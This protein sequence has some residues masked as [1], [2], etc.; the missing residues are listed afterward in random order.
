M[1]KNSVKATQSL[2]IP[3]LI[4]STGKFLQF[5][6]PKLAALFAARLFTT[7]LKYKIPK[8]ELEMDM[9]SRQQSVDIKSIDKE[10]VVYHFG[11][12]GKKVLLVHGWSG[13]GTQLVK[14]ADEFVKAGYST[15][16]FDAPAHGKSPGKTT[17]MPEFIATILQLEKEFGPFEAAVGH[18][19]GG[20]SLLNSVKRGLKLER[21]V[22]IGSG[23]IIQDIIDEFIE[24]LEL[25]PE[26]GQ[27]MRNHFEN[28]S[29]EAMDNYSAFRAAMEIDIPVL[30]IHDNDDPEVLV[31]CAHHIHE[32]LKNGELML[33]NGLG[34]RK[35]LGNHAV[36]E[37]TLAFVEN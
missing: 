17:L 23:D 2:K 28:K 32:N 1:A 10:V 6:S 4:L 25:K 18:S 24:K 26:V 9:K 21:L 22:T 34:H 29:H 13:R 11:E 14:F 31:K 8:R 37:K 27:L 33:T 15:I 20:M 19:L 3:K 5:I 12:T 30:V 35:I 16:S 36:I 7:P